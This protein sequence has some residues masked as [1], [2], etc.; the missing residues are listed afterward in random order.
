MAII[1]GPVNSRRFGNSL[2]IDLSP[3]KKCCNFDCLY[4]EVGS[5]K[6]VDEIENP[7]K[8]DDVINELK[9][10]LEKHKNLDT[11]TITANGEPTLYPYLDELI[12]KI[13]EIKKSYKLLILSN[14]SGLLNPKIFETLKMVDIAK[15]SLDS[16]VDATFK[17]LDRNKKI[18]I[19]D[20]VEVLAKFK[21][22]FSGEMVLEIL[23]VKNLNDKKEEFLKLNDAI[24]KINPDRVDLGSIDRPPAYNISG[25]SDDVLLELRKNLEFEFVNIVSR[26]M[27]KFKDDFNQDEIIKLLKLRPQ[28]KADVEFGFSEKSKDILKKLIEKNEVKKINLAGVEFYKI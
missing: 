5:S 21:K 9:S 26:K 14:S 24:K 2:G 11:I 6:V 13:N 17:K 23:V 18:V 8:V 3:N 22:E 12:K 7:P 15:F 28:S 16:V 25:V 1:F 4:C 19:S 20:L 10:A 27:A